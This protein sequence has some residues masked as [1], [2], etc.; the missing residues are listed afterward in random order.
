MNAEEREVALQ[1]MERAADEFYRSAVQIGNH[2]FIEFAGLM[3]EYITACR[4]A[5]AQGIDFS[6]CSK[7]NGMALPLHPV[8]SDYINEKLECIFTG[9]KV[10]DAEVA[11]AAF[12]PQ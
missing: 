5:H 8:M 7:H 4:Q 2:P 12:P 11:E 9:A 3:N 10:L 6:Q 1:R